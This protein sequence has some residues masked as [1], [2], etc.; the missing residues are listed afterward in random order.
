VG[1]AVLGILYKE[2]HQEGD[3]RGRGVDHELPG[4]GVSEDGTSCRPYDDQENGR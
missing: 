3:N 1:I 2:N 4:V